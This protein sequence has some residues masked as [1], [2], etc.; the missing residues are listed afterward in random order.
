MVATIKT[1]EGKEG[2]HAGEEMWVGGL[3]PNIRVCFMFH[4]KLSPLTQCN[5]AG[6]KWN[7]FKKWKLYFL[8][9]L[10]SSE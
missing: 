1:T 4:V 10:G 7:F 8:S 6:K 2:D 9:H 3:R 5:T